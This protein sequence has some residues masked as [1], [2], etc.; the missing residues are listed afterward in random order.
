MEP[1]DRS[2]DYPARLAEAASVRLATLGEQ[3]FDVPVPQRGAMG[4]RVVSPIGLNDIRFG[5]RMTDFSRNLRDGINQGNQFGNVVSVCASQ[6]D[7][8]RNAL[9]IGQD[10]MLTPQFPSIRGIGARFF[11]PPMARMEPESAMAR[12][13][14][15][16]SSERSS[17]RSISC[18]VCQ[19][20][21]ACHSA[22]RRQQVMPEPQPIS[23]GS[24]SQGIPVRSTNSSPVSAARSSKR[25]RPPMRLGVCT[26]SKGA[27]LDH[28]SS[29]TS[30]FAMSI[31]V[32][33]AQ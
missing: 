12:D 2:L 23:C 21:A 3:R 31:S 20:P 5:L 19:T 24:I 30:A 8:Q 27:T 4:F 32:S 17:L 11:P 6:V 18:S 7:N 15:N 28:S 25:G 16:L 1:R 22:S 26:G 9:C 29:L 10:V 13:Q 33:D 14:S